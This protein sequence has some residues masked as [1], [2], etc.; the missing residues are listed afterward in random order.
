MM[1]IVFYEIHA[2]VQKYSRVYVTDVMDVIIDAAKIKH[3]H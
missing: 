1:E 3:G 2:P